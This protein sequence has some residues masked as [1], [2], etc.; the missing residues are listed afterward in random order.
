MLV[1]LPGEFGEHLCGDLGTDP[2]GVSD[3][4]GEDGCGHVMLLLWG[5][6]GWEVGWTGSH[7]APTREVA[8]R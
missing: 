7:P 2:D 5:R 6:K 3:G 4:D 8:M 1:A